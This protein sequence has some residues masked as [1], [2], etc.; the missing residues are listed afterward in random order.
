[1][2]KVPVISLD[3]TDTDDEDSETKTRCKRNGSVRKVREIQMDCAIGD[4]SGSPCTTLNTVISRFGR[5]QSLR[6]PPT[7][8]T[9][10]KEENG[11]PGS[12]RGASPTPSFIDISPIIRTASLR[13]KN[14]LA[15][16]LSE[17]LKKAEHRISKL[18]MTE[19]DDEEFQHYSLVHGLKGC[20]NNDS[21][22]AG[23]SSDEDD[24]EYLELLERDSI[25]N[26]YEKGPD[27]ADV[28]AWE[29]P[30]FEVYTN[31]DRFGFVHKKGEKTDER[32]DLQKRRIIKE[33]SREKKWLKMIE[34]W[35]S[36][37]PSKKMEDRIWKGIPEK[38]RIV[39]W[40]RLLG[41]ERMKHERRDMYAELLL[42]ARLVSKDIKQ[43]DLD[44][45][46]TY[47][48][49]LAFRKRYDVKQKSLLNVLAAYSMYNTE[50][51]YCQGMSQI[52]AL[53]LMYLDEEDAFWCLHQLMVSPKHTMHGFFVPGFP[54][55]Q[56]FEEHFKKILKKYKPRVFKY[57][58]KQDIPYIYLTKWWFGCFLDR[59]PF[60]LALRLW[61]VFLVEGDSILLAMAYNIMKMHE[62]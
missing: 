49:H 10:K 60:S 57:L 23:S 44:I 28:D 41:A 12:S 8:K 40:P 2:M 45:N 35:K 43:I 37:G 62:S 29:N 47:R 20:N 22:D 55:L 11:T 26:R 21:E 54:K 34:I 13:V 33:L 56:R 6:R 1:M 58:E 38:L 3:A 48:D 9:T 14:Q 7:A 30:D 53:F 17:P 59:V 61:D 32:T 51:G 52:A 46:R 19:P 16:R 42:R 39:I 36:G 25:I 4:P 15:Q 27:A 50:V 31:L 18:L 5:S 24:P